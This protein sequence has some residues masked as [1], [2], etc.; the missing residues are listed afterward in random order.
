VT[1]ST[2]PEIE[3]GAQVDP[4]SGL[5]S[6]LY[7]RIIEKALAEVSVTTSLQ[8]KMIEDTAVL[9]E[10]QQFILDEEQQKNESTIHSIRKLE[11]LTESLKAELDSCKKQLADCESHKRAALVEVAHF[12][13]KAE[14]LY[15]HFK[16][17]KNK[18]EELESKL[19]GVMNTHSEQLEEL[20]RLL[21]DK[22]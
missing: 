1:Y 18:C 19:H 5:V 3:E 21:K 8:D 16:Q 13:E 20:T 2:Y 14:D 4:I 6:E 7:D 9:L 10:A 17:E 12:K 11:L 15:W 22:D